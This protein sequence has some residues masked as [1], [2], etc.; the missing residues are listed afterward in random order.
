MTML[1]AQTLP[2]VL[3]GRRV[4]VRAT[5]ADNNNAQ[6]AEQ[7]VGDEVRRANDLFDPAD[8]NSMLSLWMRHPRSVE[9]TPEFDDVLRV[10]LTWQ[11]L[12]NGAFNV[13]AMR[14][15][16][17]WT[18]AAQTGCRP[19]G[20]QLKKAVAEIAHAPYTFTGSELHRVDDCQG[21]DVSAVAI[22]HYADRAVDLAMLEYDLSGI[23]LTIAG[24]TARRGNNHID[25][26]LHDTTRA[27]VSPTPISTIRLHE[28]TIAVQPPR[29]RNRSRARVSDVGI[30][31]RTGNSTPVR[32]S[33]TTIARKACSAALV[34]ETLSI[35]APEEGVGFVERCN[36]EL[37]PCDLNDKTISCLILENSGFV[38]TSQSWAS[39]ETR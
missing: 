21:L 14:L 5:A 13:R 23:S 11:R 32:T 10:A 9:T 35:L 3:L 19:S 36:A 6:L 24:L 30:D 38:R 7:F 2:A 4:E 17:L 22:G 37:R 26:V 31:P 28:G 1:D 39:H 16:R 29:H 25:L 15:H 12:S 18:A 20:R 8:R 33:S 27:N 34:S